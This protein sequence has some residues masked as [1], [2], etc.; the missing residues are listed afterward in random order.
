MRKN[1][2]H[3]GAF[4]ASRSGLKDSRGSSFVLNEAC[5]KMEMCFFVTWKL[6]LLRGRLEVSVYKELVVPRGS[7]E[8]NIF[9]PFFDSSLQDSNFNSSFFS[10]KDYTLLLCV[11]GCVILVDDPIRPLSP[12]FIFSSTFSQFFLDIH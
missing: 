4:S 10:L 9:P 12:S 2:R 5:R 1:D 8:T 11:S 7:Y 3:G 6:G